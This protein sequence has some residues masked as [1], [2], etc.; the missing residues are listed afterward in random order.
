METTKLLGPATPLSQIKKLRWVEEVKQDGPYYLVRTKADQFKMALTH[1]IQ[2]GYSQYD[3][4]F[5]RGKKLAEPVAIGLP[6]YWIRLGKSSFRFFLAEKPK[7]T[8][9]GMFG[10][11][12]QY[13]KTIELDMWNTP[14]EPC[15]G[16]FNDYGYAKTWVERANAA[17][18]YLQ[19]SEPHYGETWYCTAYAYRLGLVGDEYFEGEKPQPAAITAGPEQT[20]EPVLTVTNVI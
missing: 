17:A 9:H 15:L 10:M 1:H 4:K 7:K 3:T 2:A 14:H 12:P 13:A 11:I 18:I 20:L 19:A 8:Y 5:Q 16:H 6:S